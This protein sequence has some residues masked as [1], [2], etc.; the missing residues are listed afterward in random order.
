MRPLVIGNVCRNIIDAS[1]VRNFFLLVDV[2]GYLWTSTPGLKRATAANDGEQTSFPFISDT[3][4]E[5]FC[6]DGWRNGDLP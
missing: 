4:W 5:K 2:Y 6:T 3:E 1:G